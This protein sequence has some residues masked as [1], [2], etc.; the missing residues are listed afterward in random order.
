MAPV[1]TARACDGT[2]V[3]LRTRR[4]PSSDHT[5][6]GMPALA[7]SRPPTGPARAEWTQAVREI[8]RAALRPTRRNILHWTSWAVAL[9]IEI[10]MV[11]VLRDGQVY[12][13]EQRITRALQDVPRSEVIFRATS[14]ATNTLSPPFLTAFAG[15]VLITFLF[16]RRLVASL[17]FLT[18]PL[19]VLVQFPKALVDRPRP[20][21]DFSGIEGVG[22]AMSFP[23]GHSEFVVTFY[24]FLAFLLA[25]RI[26]SGW[27]R[28]A[29]VGAWILF[30]LATGFGRV[31]EGR[32]WPLD[33]LTS[34]VV[35]LAL[36]SGMV[37]LY[38]SIRAA[39]SS[40]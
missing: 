9:A 4:L 38:S 40:P 16:G 35:G 7:A 21:S 25:R 10:T 26:S 28:A 2:G 34:Y 14:G 39:R 11:L 12:E 17:L 24:G 22:G 33:V 8:A 37:W 18:F 36:L 19:H 20:S 31:S 30:A 15:V 29:V 13:F 3:N 5:G 27:G 32:H 1:N 6:D 23:S